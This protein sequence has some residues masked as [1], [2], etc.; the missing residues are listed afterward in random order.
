MCQFWCVIEAFQSGRGDYI[1]GAVVHDGS[2]LQ[3]L[4]V[5]KLEKIGDLTAFCEIRDLLM[6]HNIDNFS[7]FLV[8]INKTI[9]SIV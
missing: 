9:N 8:H 1:F 7:Y 4:S 3:D 5:F 2:L 6:S